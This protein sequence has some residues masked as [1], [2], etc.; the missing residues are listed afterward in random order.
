MP[1]M[2]EVNGSRGFVTKDFDR[3][4]WTEGVHLRLSKETTLYTI[5]NKTHNLSP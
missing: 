3:L 4:E 1:D 2:S 5:S